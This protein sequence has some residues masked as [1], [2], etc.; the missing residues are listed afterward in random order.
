MGVGGAYAP[1]IMGSMGKWYNFNFSYSTLNNGFAT[2][3]ISKYRH[4]VAFS[5]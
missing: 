2:N 3:D 4:T 1:N 5:A